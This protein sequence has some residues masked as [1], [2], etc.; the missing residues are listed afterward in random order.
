MIAGA[1]MSLIANIVCLT[2]AMGVSILK[3]GYTAG[4]FFSMSRPFIS[5]RDLVFAIIKGAIFG[6]VIP[7]FACY[8]GLRCKPGAEGVGLATTN[9]VVSTSVAIIVLDF[10]LSYLFK[11]K[12]GSHVRDS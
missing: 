3:L 11:P 8:S 7:L 6:A 1:L 4:M 12:D 5:G 2:A 9:A 10:I